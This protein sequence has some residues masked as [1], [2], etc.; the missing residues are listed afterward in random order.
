MEEYLAELEAECPG[1]TACL[2]GYTDPARAW[3]ESPPEVARALARLAARHNKYPPKNA[4]SVAAYAGD[5]ERV[6]IIRGAFPDEPP[7]YIEEV[8]G[9]AAMRGHTEVVRWLFEKERALPARVVYF[10]IGLNLSELFDWALSVQPALDARGYQMAGGSSYP[11]YAQRLLALDPDPA[12]ENEILRGALIKG[13]RETAAQVLARGRVALTDRHYYTESLADY[14]WLD[15]LGCPRSPLPFFY[16]NSEALARELV[17][18]GTPLPKTSQLKYMLFAKPDLLRLILAA[19]VPFD[20]AELFSPRGT[21]QWTEEQ[22]RLFVEFGPRLPALRWPAPP[23]PQPY[24]ECCICLEPIRDCER[25]RAP[26]CNCN[27]RAIYHAYCAACE[28]GV[29]A[30][31]AVCRAPQMA[32]SPTAVRQQTAV[33]GARLTLGLLYG[34]LNR[35]GRNEEVCAFVKNTIANFMPHLNALKLMCGFPER[36]LALASRLFELAAEVER[37]AVPVQAGAVADQDSPQLKAAALLLHRHAFA[38]ISVINEVNAQLRAR[39]GAPLD[40]LIDTAIAAVPE[41]FRDS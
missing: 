32:A 7:P 9:V 40:V 33:E 31:C 6:Q 18:R 13:R 24:T 38:A 22:E 19:G 2:R 21:P 29:P 1:A 10:A 17:A 26:Q 41:L 5:L 37:L 16:C 27:A 36:D 34:W 39:T 15:A 20:A 11:H 4:L 23:F 25:W 12:L 28:P 35:F 14:D 8:F 30:S 3:V